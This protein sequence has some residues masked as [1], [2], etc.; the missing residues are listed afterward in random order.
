MD[1]QQSALMKEDPDF[2]E[3]KFDLDKVS[4]ADGMNPSFLHPIDG[5][6]CGSRFSVIE[7]NNP[8]G[9]LEALK[10]LKNRVEFVRTKDSP[11]NKGKK[12]ENKFYIKDVEWIEDRSSFS[13]VIHLPSRVSINVDGFG[14]GSDFNGGVWTHKV[15][16]A[17]NQLQEKVNK[18]YEE[19]Q[20]VND[21]V[22]LED[23]DDVIK[24]FSKTIKLSDSCFGTPPT[25]E[26]KYEL[27]AKALDLACSLYNTAYYDRSEGNKPIID[28]AK[29]FYD[30]IT[31]GE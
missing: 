25:N 15:L 24:R 28:I 30:Y 9:I 17:L 19:T 29:R 11:S 26:P 4:F 2:I 18:H 12:M 3:D 31:K 1:C 7:E 6:S 23:M 22:K 14:Y 21:E 8:K 10:K 5:C 16:S 20:E 27:R 13:K